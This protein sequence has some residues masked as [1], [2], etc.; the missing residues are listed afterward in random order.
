MLNGSDLRTSRPVFIEFMKSLGGG[1][2][3]SE[4]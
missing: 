3:W 1:T 4:H 2:Y